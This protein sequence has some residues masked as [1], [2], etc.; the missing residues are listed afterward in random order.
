MLTGCTAANKA[1][2]VI[3]GRKSTESMER[4]YKQERNYYI[5]EREIGI[6]NNWQINDEC[7]REDFIKEC[8]EALPGVESATVVISGDTALISICLDGEPKSAEIISV[9]ENVRST[10]LAADK[11][12][13][14]AAVSAAPELFKRTT[15]TDGGQRI[16]VS[17]EKKR[18][19]PVV[20]SF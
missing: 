2:R 1:M 7:D 4:A 13:G 17:K 5:D 8:V 6:K 14:S 18:L 3:D 10:V 9:K 11:D 20:P 12:L 16:P 15:K 19:F